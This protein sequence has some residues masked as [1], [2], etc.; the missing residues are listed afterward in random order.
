MKRI[1]ELLIVAALAALLIT[2]A[3]VGA[4]PMAELAAV[5]PSPSQ[6]P[7]RTITVIGMGKVSVVPD[8]ARANAGTE[9]KAGTVYEA[10]A[11]VD[12]QTAAIMAALL[13]IGID[14][15]DIQTTHYSIHYEREPMH[16]PTEGPPG[17]SEAGYRVSSLLRVTV[18]DIESAGEV[19]DEVVDAGA[20]Q[21][22]GVTFTASDESRWQGEA[23]EKAMADAKARAGELAGLAGVEL[24]AIQSV[25]EVIGSWPMPT[26]IV[27]EPGMGGTFAPGE[28]ELSTQV[29]V[30]YA[31]Q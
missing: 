5:P 29:Q 23:R 25:S 1:K 27:G 3:T 18:R 4:A 2:C 17:E 6:S 8:V 7:P 16:M 10:K 15:Q 19:L 28:L 21:V 24:G 30:A 14:E 22:Y 20:N 12:R 31:I 13:A 26:T 9:A 11:E